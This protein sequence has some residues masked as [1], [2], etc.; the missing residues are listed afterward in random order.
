VRGTSFGI[1]RSTHVGKDA[2]EGE[3]GCVYAPTILSRR[4]SVS[5]RSLFYIIYLRRVTHLLGVFLPAPFS[6]A[7]SMVLDI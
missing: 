7:A 4:R 1:A 3:S 2:V 5:E 6:V